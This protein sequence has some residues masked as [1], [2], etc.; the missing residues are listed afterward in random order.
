MISLIP[1]T[2]EKKKKKMRKSEFED[3]SP[4]TASNTIQ[5]FFVI[6]PEAGSGC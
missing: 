2:D 6:L 5:Y 4:M 1:D 3:R